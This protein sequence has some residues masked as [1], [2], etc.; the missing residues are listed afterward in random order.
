MIHRKV[1]ILA[2]MLAVSV[3]FASHLRE[4]SAN[5]A[6][7]RPDGMR[8]VVNDSEENGQSSV[9]R[10]PSRVFPPVVRSP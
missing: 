10:F 1:A 7:A 8:V 4:R 3:A 2:S 6:L 9:L 5:A